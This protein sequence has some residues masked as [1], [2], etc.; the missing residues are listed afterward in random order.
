[1]IRYGLAQYGMSCHVG[2]VVLIYVMLCNAML[3]YVMLC[4]CIVFVVMRCHGNGYNSKDTSPVNVF[5]IVPNL[6]LSV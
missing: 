1:M 5:L 2:C 3:V 6:S 4:Y